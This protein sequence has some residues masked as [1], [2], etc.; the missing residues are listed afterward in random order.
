MKS[1]INTNNEM[2]RLTFL[3]SQLDWNSNKLC[4]QPTPDLWISHIQGNGLM[5][6]RVAIILDTGHH[7]TSNPTD[8]NMDIKIFNEYQ[9]KLD[10]NCVKH[11]KRIKPLNIVVKIAFL[12]KL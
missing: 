2:Q 10:K 9:I 6:V 4:H 5:R 7:L 3:V 1:A 12:P 11:V 8:I